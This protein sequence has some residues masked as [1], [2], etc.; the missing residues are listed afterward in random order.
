MQ[1]IKPPNDSGCGVGE[2]AS[3]YGK[4]ADCCMGDRGEFPA[5]CLS[6]RSQETTILKDSE[7]VLSSGN[8][9]ETFHFG[10]LAKHYEK[11]QHP[12]MVS[13][14]K[15]RE[16]HA[17]PGPWSCHG[18]AQARYLVLVCGRQNGPDACWI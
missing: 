2:S 1:N 6:N 10:V 5:G 3:Y 11:T 14:R 17:S 12:A 4:P 16:A 18:L 7:Q 13:L 15:D 9:M 8:D